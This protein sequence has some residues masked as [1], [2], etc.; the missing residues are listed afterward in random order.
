MLDEPGQWLSGLSPFLHA[1]F[2]IVALQVL[3]RDE[4]D[5]GRI[6]S[7]RLVD[8]E[9]RRSVRTHGGQIRD[10]Y[11]SAMSQHIAQLRNALGKHG[12]DHQLWTTAT[13]PIEALRGYV[14][15]RSMATVA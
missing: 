6:G 7:V 11:R 1:Q 9:T 13:P 14:A 15:R 4:L 12:V 2:D 3:S 10:R 5:P 8:A